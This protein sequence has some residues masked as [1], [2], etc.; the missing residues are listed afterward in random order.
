MLG[1]LA[2]AVAAPAS[3][4][5]YRYVDQNGVA[6]FSDVSPETRAKMLT[7]IG[8]KRALSQSAT[9]EMERRFLSLIRSTATRH[10]MDP[11][12]VRAV[13]AVESGFDS[14]AVSRRGA[15]G[16][17]QLMP[18]TARSYGV[19]NPFSPEDNV[20][21]GTQYLK[22]L[23]RSFDGNLYLALAAYNAGPTAVFRYG[24]IPPFP[25]TT[26]YVRKVL[27]LY[28]GHTPDL[29]GSIASRTTRVAGTDLKIYR[30]RLD[31][32]TVLY[33]NS[34]SYLRDPRMRRRV[35]EL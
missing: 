5:M 32:G 27:T 3:G 12:L 15:K 29:S 9:K 13:I 30:V 23:I 4:E 17:M 22:H 8:T 11:D 24:A 7:V 28:N 21:A 14:R 16:L 1:F 33:T 18:E 19:S 26:N 2:L 20:S 35:D 34:D 31:D 6:T 10:G 25:E